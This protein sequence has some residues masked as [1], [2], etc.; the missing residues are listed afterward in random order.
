MD[1][2]HEPRGPCCVSRDWTRSLPSSGLSVALQIGVGEPRLGNGQLEQVSG[3]KEGRIS[4]G[5]PP[6]ES[7]MWIKSSGL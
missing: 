4:L 5:N 3:G 6:A 1:C 2:I 7:A